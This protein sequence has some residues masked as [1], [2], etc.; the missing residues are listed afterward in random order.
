MTTMMQLQF[1]HQDYQKKAVGAVVEGSDGQPLA[2]GEFSLAAGTADIVLRA[3]HSVLP[4]Q[5]FVAELSRLQLELA[6][7][8]PGAKT[9]YG[10]ALSAPVAL[11]DVEPAALNKRPYQPDAQAMQRVELLQQ[12]SQ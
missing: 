10:R 12:L 11:G 9:G 7:P 6:P 5:A 8:V 3:H 1:S 4:A 2:K